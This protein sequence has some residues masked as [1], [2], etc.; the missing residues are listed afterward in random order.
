[1]ER[2]DIEWIT[3]ALDYDKIHVIL[4]KRRKIARVWGYVVMK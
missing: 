2:V 1:M 3:Q 4:S